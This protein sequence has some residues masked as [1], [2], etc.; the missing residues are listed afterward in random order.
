MEQQYNKSDI[1][2]FN[3]IIIFRVCLLQ[4]YSKSS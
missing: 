2:V 4:D 1:I 3:D